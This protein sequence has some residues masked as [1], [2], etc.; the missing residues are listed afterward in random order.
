MKLSYIS[1]STIPSS[2]ANAVHV[3]KMCQALARLPDF[4]VSLFGKR[5]KTKDNPYS[6]YGVKE[7]FRLVRSP[8]GTTPY[9]SGLARLSSLFFKIGLIPAPQVFYGRD[10]VGLY[11]LSFSNEPVF[12]EAHQVPKGKI[13]RYL[14]KKLLRRKSFKG[15]IV[16]SEGL[17][18]DFLKAFPDYSGPVLVAHDGADVTERNPRGIPA[19][20][21]AGRKDARQIGYTGSLHKGRGMEVI[22][23][24]A[25]LLPEMDFHVVGGSPADLKY[26]KAQRPPENLYMHGNKPHS[27]M[28]AYLAKFDVVLAPYQET[29]KIGTGADISRWISPMKLFEYMAAGKAIIASDLPVLR[30]ILSHGRNATLVPPSDTNRWVEAICHVGKSTALRQAMGLEGEKDIQDIYSWNKRAIKIRDFIQTQTSAS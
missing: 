22:M 20:D 26:W 2:K 28:N 7:N 11:L 30:E 25:S 29:I 23:S 8:L 19:K 21:W 4:D 14:T 10:I 5:G 18:L 6:Y 17:K 3:M 15:L 12:Y 16:I 24:V 1:G 13:Q 9:L 27:Q